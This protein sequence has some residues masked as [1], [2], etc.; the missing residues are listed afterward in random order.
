[1]KVYKQKR[2]KQSKFEPYRE[3]ISELIDSGLKIRE[4]AD[5]IEPLM[6]DIVDENAL[7]CYIRSKDLLSKNGLSVPK[8]Q[9]CDGCMMITNTNET[10]VLLCLPSKR[11]VNRSCQ[12]S[13]QWCSK[14]IMKGAVKGE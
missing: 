4:I 5:E 2:P 3:M 8:C 9:G 1:M 13:P 14:R 10:E 6:D 12:T 7:Y 11:I